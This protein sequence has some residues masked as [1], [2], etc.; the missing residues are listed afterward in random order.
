M[1]ILAPK[2]EIERVISGSRQMVTR[3]A[4]RRPN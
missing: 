2:F 4:V 3:R 1:G